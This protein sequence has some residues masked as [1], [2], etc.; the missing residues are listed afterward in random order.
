MI[1]KEKVP[2]VE[3]EIKKDEI[4][5]RIEMT[6]DL[7]VMDLV[8][9]NEGDGINPMTAAESAEFDIKPEK[10]IKENLKMFGMEVLHSSV[11]KPVVELSDRKIEKF[12]EDINMKLMNSKNLPHKFKNVEEGDWYKFE[13]QKKKDKLAGFDVQPKLCL[14]YTSP[15]PRD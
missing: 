15:S 4:F 3:K 2:A 11:I 6:V 9:L 13:E 14:L 1:E 7:S 8:Y 12:N 5:E 10:L